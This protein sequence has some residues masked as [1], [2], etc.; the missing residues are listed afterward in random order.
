VTIRV[1]LVLGAG[2]VVGHAWH[3]GV[4]RALQEHTGWDP[5]DAD[6]IVGTSAGAVV[7]A[8]LRAEIEPADIGP[9]H[10]GPAFAASP[11]AGLPRM[12]APGMLVRQVARPWQARVG[13]LSAAMLPEGR[14]STEVVAAGVRER[15]GDQWPRRSLFINAVRLDTGQRVTFGRDRTPRPDVATAVAASIAI[16][17]FFAPVAIDGVRYVDGG[18]HSPTNADVVADAHVDLVVVS[19]PMSMG[20]SE[21]RLRADQGPRRLARF[22][23]SREVATLRRR[24]IRVLAIQPRPDDRAVMGLNAMDGVR[25]ARVVEQAAASA[26]QR[27]Q[28]P[29]V[30]EQ[31]EMLRAVRRG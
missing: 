29:D 19:S 26:R 30:V 23:L 28:R 24:G 10:N 1:G 13:L 20:G 27:L 7:G 4:L 8:A 25:A 14:V 3:G 31:V 15:F 5:R 21:I 18:A 11:R 12:A 16:P 22:Y 2:G 9:R 6:V 17:G